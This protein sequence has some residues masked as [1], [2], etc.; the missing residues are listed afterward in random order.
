MNLTEPLTAGTRYQITLTA[1]G[2]AQ[3]GYCVVS[4]GSKKL[5]SDPIDPTE[6]LSFIF[7]PENNAVY[8]FTGVWGSYTDKAVIKDGVIFDETTG[9]LSGYSALPAMASNAADPNLYIVQSGDT[10]WDI[11]RA[12]GTTVEKLAA[13]NEIEDTRKI[14]IG[15][16]INIPPE[17]YDIPQRQ[18][19]SQ[20]D[21]VDP[22][23]SVSTEGSA[24]NAEES[25]PSENQGSIPTEAA[26]AE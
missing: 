21:P 15:D 26:K 2:T 10:L 6:T 19:D 7:I 23:D 22:S 24:E 17:N 11:A 3:S 18:Q 14:Q 12:Y 20:P 8:S 25:A 1:S 16:V 13:Y 4:G 9:S 5:Y